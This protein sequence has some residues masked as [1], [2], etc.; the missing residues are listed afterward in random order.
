MVVCAEQIVNDFAI[1]FFAFKGRAAQETAE[2]TIENARPRKRRRRRRKGRPRRWR[3]GREKKIKE[4]E[5]G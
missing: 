4:T 2:R 5:D 1:A 3:G